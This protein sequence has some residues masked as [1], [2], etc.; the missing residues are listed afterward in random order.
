MVAFEICASAPQT[1]ILAHALLRIP[2]VYIT[3]EHLGLVQASG[4]RRDD[5]CWRH[6]FEP[7]IEMPFT[8][9]LCVYQLRPVLCDRQ[10]AGDDEA[11]LRWY[12]ECF[13]TLFPPAS[14]P[15]LLRITSMARHSPPS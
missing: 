12:N 2:P 8:A 1:L 13:Q 14:C 15:H 3:F 6:A 11:V 4:G 5:S 7:K 9:V 10:D